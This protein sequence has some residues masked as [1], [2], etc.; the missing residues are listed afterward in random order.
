MQIGEEEELYFYE[1]LGGAD[2]GERPP[3]EAVPETLRPERGLAVTAGVEAYVRDLRRA[4]EQRE[5]AVD[6][7][8]SGVT[9]RRKR[10]EALD[11]DVDPAEAEEL[12]R[13]LRDLS[14]YL[15]EGD[16]TALARA[17]KRV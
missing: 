12:V 2:S 5:S 7:V 8:L 15:R 11:G 10:V 9:A 3:P 17:Q 16:E 6:S 4:V 1:L 13:T 14:A